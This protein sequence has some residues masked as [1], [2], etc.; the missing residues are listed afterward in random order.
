MHPVAFAKYILHVL[1]QEN[2]VIIRA[3]TVYRYI[4]VFSITGIAVTQ[5]IQISIYVINLRRN[6][7][8]M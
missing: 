6:R 8:A 2:T 5:S 3:K 1:Y 7:G 4:F